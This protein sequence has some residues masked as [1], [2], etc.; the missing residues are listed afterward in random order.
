MARDP[1]F[2]PLPE[3]PAGPIVLEMFDARSEEWLVTGGGDYQTA[4]VEVFNADGTDVRRLIALEWPARVNH[5]T[6]RRT[7][8]LLIHPEDAEGLAE[9]LAHSTAWLASLPCCAG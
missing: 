4:A 5:S 8:R 9:V 1:Q 6:E 2:R 7:V 3:D